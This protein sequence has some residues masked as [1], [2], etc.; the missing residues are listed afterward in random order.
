MVSL[1]DAE[2]D[3]L[4]AENQRK[5]EYQRSGKDQSTRRRAAKSVQLVI[6]DVINA[7]SRGFG[8]YRKPLLMFFEH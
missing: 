4:L 7:D 2:A 1:T 5:Q 3:K 8:C 6:D